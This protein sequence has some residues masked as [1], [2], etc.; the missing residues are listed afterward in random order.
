LIGGILKVDLVGTDTETT[1]D[2]EV[3]GLL[4]DSCGELGL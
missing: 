4:Q 1:D 2:D 3:L